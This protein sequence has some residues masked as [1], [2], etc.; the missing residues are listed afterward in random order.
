MFEK[1][2]WYDILTSSVN[3]RSNDPCWVILSLIELIELWEQ[4]EETKSLCFHIHLQHMSA[5]TEMKW[6]LTHNAILTSIHAG[7]QRLTITLIQRDST[8]SRALTKI[9]PFSSRFV[10]K[11]KSQST[12]DNNI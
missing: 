1:M 10:R 4:E 8:K 6:L 7:V 11:K 12:D 9:E 2:S 3:N 5:M